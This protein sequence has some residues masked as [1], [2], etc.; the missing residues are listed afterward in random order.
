MATYHALIGGL[1]EQGEVDE[2]LKLKDKMVA[3]LV[4]VD[5]VTFICIIKGFASLVNTRKQSSFLK[6]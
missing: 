3:T 6:V 1:L 4:K 5:I 2:A